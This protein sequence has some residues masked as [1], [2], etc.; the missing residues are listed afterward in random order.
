MSQFEYVTV[1]VSIVM[2]LAV[3]EVLAG[4]G[5]LIR[6]RDHV[7]VYW[8]HVAWMLL[9]ILAVTQ[10]WWVIWNIRSHEF[11]NFFE[12]LTLVVPRLI[13]VL[14]AFLLSPPISSDRPFD[15]YEYYFRHIRW[16]A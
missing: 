4:L 15:L 3:A 2:A 10:S 9:A 6:E 14:V 7:R 13:F 16:I 12:F 5:R 8:V 1:F 11:A